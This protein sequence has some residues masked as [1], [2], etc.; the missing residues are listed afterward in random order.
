MQVADRSC[1]F[2]MLDGASLRKV[3]EDEKPDFIVLEIEAIATGTLIEL[4]AEGFSVIPSARAAQLTMN[5]EYIR[6]LAAEG[7]GP[8][9]SPYEFAGDKAAFDAAVGRIGMPCVIKPIISSSGDV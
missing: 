6:R 5:R 2:S 3:I 8:A 7:L 9:T 4:E 1:A